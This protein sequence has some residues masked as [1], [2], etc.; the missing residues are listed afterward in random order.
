MVYNRRWYNNFE[1]IYNNIWYNL[2]SN[3]FNKYYQQDI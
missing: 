2:V 1:R 3:N